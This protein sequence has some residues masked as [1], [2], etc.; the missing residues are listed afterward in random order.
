M[1]RFLNRLPTDHHPRGPPREGLHDQRPRPAGIRRRR[2]CSILIGG[3]HDSGAS[4]CPRSSLAVVGAAP[5]QAQLV[6]FDP[7]NLAQTILI[8]QRTQRALRGAAWRSTRP[9]CGW[10][11]GSATSDRYRLPTIARSRHDA[12]PVAVRRARGSGAEQRRPDGR[13]VLVHDASPASGR[14]PCPARLTACGAASTRAAVRHHRDHRLRR[15]DG[16][17]S[18]RR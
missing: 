14:R 8:A 16:R 12:E 9:S 18:G 7:A 6:V 4:S 15:H 11:R 2:A 5:A 3:C 1:N 13:R 10:R 17:P